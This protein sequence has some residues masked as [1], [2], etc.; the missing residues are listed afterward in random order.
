[1]PPRNVA[2]F[3]VNLLHDIIICTVV[4]INCLL[5]YLS[6]SRR[7]YNCSS[8]CVIRTLLYCKHGLHYM[9]IT[10]IIYTRMRLNIRN[11]CAQEYYMRHE[12]F[13]LIRRL[14]QKKYCTKML[15]KA[16]KFISA[17]LT[18]LVPQA[19]GKETRHK[20]DYIIVIIH[21]LRVSLFFSSTIF[22]QQLPSFE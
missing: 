14:I 22:S 12:R 16:L 2:H 15:N 3:T 1:M 18:H 19:L 5:S 17:A 9:A 4:I 13:A 11:R 21:V 7:H 10:T 20:R 6:R 8:L